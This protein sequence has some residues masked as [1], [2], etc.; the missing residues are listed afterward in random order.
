MDVYCIPGMGVDERLFRNIKLNNCT[1]HYIKWESVNSNESLP[2]YAMRLSKNIDTSKPFV[3]IGVSFG[4]MCAIEIAKKTK[5]VKI[6]LISSCKIADELPFKMVMWKMMPFYKLLNDDFFKRSTL[7]IE[8]QFG[9]FSKEQ[10]N[11][12]HEMLNTAP[13][14]YFARAIN[15]ILTWK[16]NVIPENVIHIHGNADQLLPYKNMNCDYLINGGTHFM[17]VNKA[18]EISEIINNELNRV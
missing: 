9:V 17:V 16:N 10:K 6:F 12:F 7:L 11:R 15:C 13:K 8:K 5:P 1:I 2:E 4:G 18:D 14:D 3:L